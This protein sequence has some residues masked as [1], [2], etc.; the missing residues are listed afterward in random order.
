[1]T[2]RA[3][4]TKGVGKEQVEQKETSDRGHEKGDSHNRRGR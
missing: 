4:K 3:K 1:M 2:R